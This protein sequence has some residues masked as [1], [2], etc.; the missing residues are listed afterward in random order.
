[1][2]PYYSFPVLPACSK[3]SCLLLP[4]AVSMHLMQSHRDE[5]IFNTSSQSEH[6]VFAICQT[7]LPVCFQWEHF[8]WYLL[9]TKKFQGQR[10]QLPP[11]S[12]KQAR[13]MGAHPALLPKKKV[14][15]DPALNFLGSRLGHTIALY[16][17]MERYYYYYHALYCI[18]EITLF[19]SAHNGLLF[20]IAQLWALGT[21][22]IVKLNTFT[23][24]H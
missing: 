4:S 8:L 23:Y 16:G 21:S 19:I 12:P 15:W 5:I 13:Q 10:S 22:K 9:C 1:M 3:S 11:I 6:A 24:W 14:L 18:L 20:A 2:R 17:N 7:E